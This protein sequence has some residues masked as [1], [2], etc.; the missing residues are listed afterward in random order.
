[1]IL[2]R[3]LVLVA[4]MVVA[5]GG[6]AA[7][8][9]RN[10]TQ[11][12]RVVCDKLERISK[13]DFFLEW[14]TGSVAIGEQCSGGSCGVYLPIPPNCDVVR[15]QPPVQKNSI[16]LFL[17]NSRSCQSS[18]CEVLDG[19]TYYAAALIFKN[20]ETSFEDFFSLELA[21]NSGWMRRR[22]LTQQR[23]YRDKFSS[24]YWSFDPRAE[25][26]YLLHGKND[27]SEFDGVISKYF[28][29]RTS[30]DG[31]SSWDMREFFVAVGDKRKG[32]QE[33]GYPKP[34]TVKFF[35]RRFNE[36]VNVVP[37]DPAWISA[38]ISNAYGVTVWVRSPSPDYAAYF[39][40]EFSVPAPVRNPANSQV[41]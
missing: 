1:M 22:V 26:F 23:Y 24:G 9:E 41:E 3:I 21:R 30:F 6:S 39:D 38:R 40:I 11:E 16:H 14:Q 17:N 36:V 29:A 19:D 34:C 10:S 32:C 27:I 33:A 20:S 4:V 37:S 28:H 31:F 18:G 2:F 35:L 25:N 13:R 15:Y 7:L 12:D 8:S 5:G